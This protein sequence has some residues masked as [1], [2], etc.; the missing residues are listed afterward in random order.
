MNLGTNAAYA[1]PAGGILSVKLDCCRLS[2]AEATMHKDLR[3]GMYVR[4][5]VQDTGTGMSGETRSRIFEPFFTTKGA[6]GTGLGLSVVHGIVKSHDGAIK[7]ESELGNGSTFQAYFPAAPVGESHVA[8]TTKIP[9]PGRG[10]HIMYIDD[11]K[12]LGSSMKRVLR[13]LGYR[14]SY[15]SEA[16]DAL[17]AFRSSPEK[18]DAVITD[19]IMPHL[20]GLSVARELRAIRPNVPV[21]LYSGRFDQVPGVLSNSENINV[22]IPKGSTIAELAVGLEQLL[23]NCEPGG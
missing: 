16:Q 20:S 12:S 14:C 6:E 8:G 7:V 4:L 9:A 15:Y 13:F 21:A 1:M 17:D 22:R 19:L 10:Q 11:E 5:T 2:D 18:F 23:Q 3:A